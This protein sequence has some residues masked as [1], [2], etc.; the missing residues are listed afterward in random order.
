[1]WKM[2]LGIALV[3]SLATTAMAGTIEWK[4]LD[5]TTIAIDN[6]TSTTVN[7]AGHL[8][9]TV[10]NDGTPTNPATDNWKVYAALPGNLTQANRPWVMFSFLD[11]GNLASGGPRA[12]LDTHQDGLETMLQAGVFEGYADYLLNRSGWDST[13]SPA[14]W[15]DFSGF[16]WPGSR[17][18]GEHTFFIGMDSDGTTDLWFDGV[19]QYTF[20]EDRFSFFQTAFLGI[21]TSGVFTGT[22]TDFRFGTAYSGKPVPEPAS[23]ALLACGA[24]GLVVAH[25]RRRRS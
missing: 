4:G 15:G 1:M 14:D 6:G 7:G 12:Y 5:W 10:D 8:E 13:K 25:R 9:V 19:K 23:L 3:L 16:I 11:D 18:A 17:T 20:Q 22:Y 21:N 2:A 24:V